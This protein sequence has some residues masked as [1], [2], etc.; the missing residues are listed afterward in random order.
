[1]WGLR[2]PARCITVPQGTFEG[3]REASHLK[4]KLV[5]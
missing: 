5:R 3:T 1:V 4:L 2:A